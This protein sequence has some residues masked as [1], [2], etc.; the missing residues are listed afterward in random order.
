[1]SIWIVSCIFWFV[2]CLNWIT[3]W[4]LVSFVFFGPVFCL[5]ESYHCFLI[6]I[7]L[8]MSWFESIHFPACAILNRVNLLL[9]TIWFDYNN[10]W[11][12][13]TFIASDLSFCT[14]LSRII[15]SV[16]R[17]ISLF[18]PQKLHLSLLYVYSYTHTPSNLLNQ[19]KIT[20]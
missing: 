4:W 11:I 2:F 6:R 20:F 3:S 9:E 5:V 16:I 1:M 14:C 10:V 18:L 8:H 15:L 7:N 13:S 17:I 19:L 12:V